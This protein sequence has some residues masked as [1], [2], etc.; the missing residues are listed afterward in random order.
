MIAP[1][2]ITIHDERLS[3][4]TSELQV[5]SIGELYEGKTFFMKDYNIAWVLSKILKEAG[6]H[7]LTENKDEEGKF[8]FKVIHPQYANPKLFSPTSVHRR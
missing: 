1:G 4:I 5:W 3:D 2:Q 7:V 6:W 8:A